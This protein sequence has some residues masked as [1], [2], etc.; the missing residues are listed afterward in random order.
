LESDIPSDL[1]LVYFDAFAPSVSP[2]LWTDAVF[3]KLYDAMVPGGVLATFCAKGKVKR[4]LEKCGFE[5]QTLP[6]PPGKREVVRAIKK[7]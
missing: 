2:E 3:K 6:G 4:N 5:I 1:H 7:M